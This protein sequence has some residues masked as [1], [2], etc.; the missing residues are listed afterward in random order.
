MGNDGNWRKPDTLKLTRAA[1]RLYFE[2][3]NPENLN[4]TV[5]DLCG[6]A[7]VSPTTYYEWMKNDEFVEMVN[8]EHRRLVGG[9]IGNVL[10]ATYKYALEEKGHADRKMLLTWAGEYADKTE[11]KLEGTVDIGAVSNRLERYLKTD[12]DNGEDSITEV[13]D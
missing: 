7:G 4:L 1:K 6:K 3:I 10:Q 12:K 5:S 13:G 9:K 11:T 8:A 2:L